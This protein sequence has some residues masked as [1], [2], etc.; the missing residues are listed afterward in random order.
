MTDLITKLNELSTGNEPFAIA[1][2]VRTMGS[3][4]RDLGTKLLVLENGTFFGSIGGGR[5]EVLVIQDTLQCL[6]ERR[7]ALRSYSLCAKTD[8]CCDGALDIFIEIMNQKPFLYIFGAGHIG[9]A[10][11]E[12]L[13]H[14]PF[15]LHLVDERSEWLNHEKIPSE[16]IRHQKTFENFIATAHW[17]ERLIYTVIMTY[18]HDLDQKIVAALLKHKMYYLGLIGSHSKWKRFQHRLLLQGFSSEELKHVHCPIGLPTG[19]K[20]PKEVAISL[21]SQL[22]SLYYGRSVT[23]ISADS[24]CRRKILQNGVSERLDALPGQAVASRPAPPAS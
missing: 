17:N 7:S 21:A 18:S 23:G 3:T 6:Q 11:C 19:G 16:V 22:L 14:T 12:V 15:Q 8:Q 10:V 20:S 24:S 5:L 2:I 4:P 13:S 9:Q 1:T